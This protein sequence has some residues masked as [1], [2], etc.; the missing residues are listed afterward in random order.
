MAKRRRVNAG[1]ISLKR[2]KHGKWQEIS[3][4]NAARKLEEHDGHKNEG[5]ERHPAR[6]RRAGAH[7]PQH[8]HRKILLRFRQQAWRATPTGKWWCNAHGDDVAFQ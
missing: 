8:P 7:L 2:I 3:S 4:K 6:S 5:Q 1:D